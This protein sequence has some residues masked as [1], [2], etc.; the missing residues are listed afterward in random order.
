MET[1]NEDLY[2]MQQRFAREI[3]A[4]RQARLGSRV[5]TFY[6]GRGYYP[7]PNY[8]Y[9]NRDYPDYYYAPGPDYYYEPEPYDYGYYPPE[10]GYD[11]GPSDGIRAFFGL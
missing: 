9:G 11:Y 10:P 8:A 3:C 2:Y 6:S 5:R 1:Q 7:G 4:I